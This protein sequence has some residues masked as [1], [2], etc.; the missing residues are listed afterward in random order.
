MSAWRERER[1]VDLPES[2]A[3]EGGSNSRRPT[4]GQRKLQKDSLFRLMLMPAAKL[5]ISRS[6]CISWSHVV[7]RVTCSLLQYIRTKMAKGL[8]WA[9]TEDLARY[10]GQLDW[11]KKQRLVRSSCW[12][13]RRSLHNIQDLFD[14]ADYPLFREKGASQNTSTEL[15]FS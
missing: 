13:L 4:H 15:S 8:I 2:D 6:P 5:P 3:G 14:A 10:R 7:S 1:G 12:L 9:T 11:Q